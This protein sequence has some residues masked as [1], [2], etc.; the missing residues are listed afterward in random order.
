MDKSHNVFISWSGQRSAA[1][2]NFLREWLPSV[3]QAARP[4]VSSHSIEAGSRNQD[5]IAKALQGCKCGITCLAPEN[6]TATWI[7]YEAGALS[8]TIDEKTRLCTYLLGGLQP[9][10][11]PPPLG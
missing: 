8:K 2:A 7:L 1:V 3:I 9:Q 6:L 5:E 11:V 10:E 4:W